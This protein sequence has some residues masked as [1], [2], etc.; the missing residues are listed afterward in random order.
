MMIVI[1]FIDFIITADLFLLERDKDNIVSGKVEI[2][3]LFALQ[4][5]LPEVTVLRKLSRLTE[6]YTP[7][8]KPTYLSGMHI[9]LPKWVIS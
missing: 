2:I 1:M 9:F 5:K 3:I 7:D 6:K 4:L 8:T